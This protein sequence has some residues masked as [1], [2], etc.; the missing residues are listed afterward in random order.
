MRLRSK[1]VLALLLLPA[2]LAWPARR[3]HAQGVLP[4]RLSIL[5]AS[6]DAPSLDVYVDGTRSLTGLAFSF[7]SGYIGLLP[8][9]HRVQVT[10]TNRLDQLLSTTA[11]FD[12]GRS[13]TWVLSGVI[14]ATDLAVPVTSDLQF[15]HYIQLVDN[16]GP[17]SDAGARLR[18]VNASPGAGPLDVRADGPASAML[19]SSLGYGGTS[20]YTAIPEGTYTVS[21]IEPASGAL[22]AAFSGLTLEPKSAYTAVVTGAVPRVI[23]QV[24]PNMVRGLNLVRLPDQT[25]ARLQP[26]PAGCD[27][28][29][30]NL[31][32]GTP[33]SAVLGY[34]TDPGLVVSIWRVD[35]ALKMLQV[36]FFQDQQA[37]V[38]NPATLSS[39]ELIYICV[40]SATSWNPPS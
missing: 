6:P 38:D 9:T 28:S 19:A 15:Q 30:L 20:V 8:G 34:V 25:S 18:V 24:P 13:Y 21:I 12:A 11:T 32:A 27:Q 39:P 23:P 35:S 33:F 26:L 16:A 5:H 2:L 4:A 14:L 36:G 1:L 37:P 3:G 7:A 29:V 10:P 17:P 22:I 40:S 31:S